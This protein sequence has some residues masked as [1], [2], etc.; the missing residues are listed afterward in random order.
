MDLFQIAFL[1]LIQGLTEF[2]PISSSAHLAIVPKLLNWN[3]PGLTVDAFLH[4]G[5]LLAVL[6]Y[7]FKDIKEIVLKKHD[8]LK[9]ILIASL[10]VVLIGLAIKSHLSDPSDPMS[11]YVRSLPFM[12]STLIIGAIILFIAEKISSLKKG[13]SSLK[14]PDI[15]MIGLAQALALMPGISRSGITI[16][17]GML[18]GLKRAE[19]ARFTFL[20]GVP[21]ILGAGILSIK[22]ICDASNGTVASTS[23]DL[24]PLLLGLLISFVS[25]YLAI[26]FLIKLLEKHSTM[27][28]IIYRIIFGISLLTSFS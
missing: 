24:M 4:L 7:F 21:A 25:G 16:A 23:F 20:L 18:L 2:L 11:I 27:L 5:T 10:P 6:I 12:G 8:L 19:A 9:A 1:G 26:H 17:A 28:F 13:I 14:M 3:D 15:F 22:D